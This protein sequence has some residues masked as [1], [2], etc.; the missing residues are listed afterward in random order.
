M[1]QRSW[2]R[3]DK[4]GHMIAIDSPVKVLNFALASKGPF[5]NRASFVNNLF[6][7]FVALPGSW[8][9][10]RSK[11]FAATSGSKYGRRNV[12]SGLA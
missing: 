4:A 7:L 9:S 6:L 3:V 11:A 8:F 12:H 2:S 5:S 1:G 10:P